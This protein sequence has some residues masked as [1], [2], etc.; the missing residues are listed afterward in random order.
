VWTFLHLVENQIITAE[1]KRGIL[2]LQAEEK[3]KYE[4]LVRENLK[5]LMEEKLAQSAA[6]GARKG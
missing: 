6:G 3:N 5:S 4:A 1:E 2:K